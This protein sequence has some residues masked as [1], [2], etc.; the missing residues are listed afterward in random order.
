MTEKPT[1]ALSDLADQI[2]DEF[3]VYRQ[4]NEF[5]DISLVIDNDERIHPT[6]IV[7]ID[8]DDAS[9]LADRLDKFLQECGAQTQREQ[10]SESDIRVLATL[11]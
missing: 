1:D 11:D 2:D 3:E 8:G 6:L 5:K 10:Y 9:S 4:P 7:H